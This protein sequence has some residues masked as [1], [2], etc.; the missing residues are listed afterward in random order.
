ME[1]DTEKFV[2]TINGLTYFKFSN[3]KQIEVMTG[4]AATIIKI[5]LQD[6]LI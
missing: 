1:G 4:R 3:G 2:F 6:L 5:D